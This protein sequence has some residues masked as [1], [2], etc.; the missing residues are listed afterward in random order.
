M[1]GTREIVGDEEEADA[2]TEELGLLPE[3]TVAIAAVGKEVDPV[4][5]F[6]LVI[7]APERFVE[8]TDNIEDVTGTQ[9][10]VGMRTVT[11]D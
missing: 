2:E 11:T 1:L 3:V 4:R 10:P 7:G 6:E 9:E 8:L 5:L